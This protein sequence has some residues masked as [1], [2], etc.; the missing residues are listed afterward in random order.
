MLALSAPEENA[1]VA[2]KKLVELNADGPLKG[3]KRLSQVRFDPGG[4]KLKLQSLA[5][6]GPSRSERRP[7]CGCCARVLRCG[8]FV[9]GG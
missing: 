8:H 3:H 9:A 6:R 7:W 5:R 4:L 1:L 2:W